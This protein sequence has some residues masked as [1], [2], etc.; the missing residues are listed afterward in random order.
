M[1]EEAGGKLYDLKT[2]RRLAA[3][4]GPY[5]RTV[6]LSVGLLFAAAATEAL[7]PMLTKIAIDR[8]LVKAPEAIP[9]WIPGSFASWLSPDAIRGFGQ[10]SLLYLSALIVELIVKFFQQYLMTRTGQQAM[11]DLRRDIFGHLQRLD[12]RFYDRNPIG[13]LVTRMTND[14]DA[15]NEL[16][17][18]GLVTLF[19]DLVSLSIVLALMLTLSWKL[20]LILLAILPLVF[21]ATLVFRA[22]AQA[23]YRRTR[24]AVAKINAF[25]QEHVAGISVLQLFNGEGRAQRQFRK[26]N[27]EHMVAFKDSIFAYGWFYP[28]VDFLSVCALA[29]LL[30]WGGWQA[31][32]G[33]ITLGVVAAFFQYGLRFFRP[34]QD[35]SEK[36]NIL[37]SATTAAERVLHLLDTPPE[38]ADAPTPKPLP[39]GEL[40][41]EFDHVW[42]AYKG[43]DW[44]LR[45]LSFRIAP[46][47][48]I[49]VV[50]HT[51]AGKTTLI[52]LLLRF[53]DVQ[54]GSIRL[55]G[56]DLRELPLSEVRGRAGVVLQDPYLFTGSLAENVRLGTERISDEDIHRAARL[57]NLSDL[58]R[59]LPDGL[60]HTVRE[61][62]AG[63]ST[64]QKQLVSFARALAHDPKLLILD[65]ATASVDTETELRIREA[66][67]HLVEGRTS[68]IIAHRLSTIQRADRIFVM[69]KGQLR[70]CGTHQQLLA[71]RGIYYR[72]YQ[73]Q[74]KDQETQQPT[75]SATH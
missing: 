18:S 73:L 46:G 2:L 65:E 43:E 3:Y 37:Q 17:S 71:L 68:I 50:G 6:L 38:I 14:V 54:K 31:S 4:L 69:H 5:R 60:R 1:E 11:F 44:V 12:L 9:S 32:T 29:G 63:L 52:S 64:G 47:E 13:R 49:A 22:Q 51:G 27:E 33:D 74:Y 7:R 21:W 42:F 66:L 57:V 45:D 58:I 56:V 19:G 24:V 53:Y 20:T 55:G 8:Y 48:T 59:Q 41:I 70:E 36:Y 62:G 26:V 30:A 39:Q 15:L 35:L 23:S 16:Y 28:V 72:L 67:E 40:P 10:I 75:G 34:I 61:R 25:L